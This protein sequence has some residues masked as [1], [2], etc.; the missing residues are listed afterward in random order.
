[1]SN[2]AGGD[3]AALTVLGSVTDGEMEFVSLL[4]RDGVAVPVNVAINDGLKEVERLDRNAFYGN[5]FV[6]GAKTGFDE[7]DPRFMV[8]MR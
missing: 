5:G 4:R 3:A 6:V 2:D 7:P 1:M 8:A